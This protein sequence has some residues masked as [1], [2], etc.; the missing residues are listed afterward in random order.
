MCI[1]GLLSIS[2]RLPR[3]LHIHSK[4]KYELLTPSSSSKPSAVAGS[5]KSRCSMPPSAR[6][7]PHERP[8]PVTPSR[9]ET[10]LSFEAL[11]RPKPRPALP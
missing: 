11:Q 7:V 1:C 8:R 10:P 3:S 9:C 5:R 4:K 6:C 2:L